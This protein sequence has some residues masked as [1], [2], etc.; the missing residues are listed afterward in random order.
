MKLSPAFNYLTKIGVATCIT[1]YSTRINKSLTV[2][3]DKIKN[4]GVTTKS[5][6]AKGR[7]GL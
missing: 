7:G 6:G 4:P 1:Q 3:G 5:T 2:D